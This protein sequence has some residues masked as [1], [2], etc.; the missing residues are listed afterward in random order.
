MVTIR[1][2][3]PLDAP[4]LDTMVRELAACEDSL[5]HVAVDAAAWA[6]ILARPDV[7][8]LIAEREGEPVGFV[9][10]V[11]RLHLWSGKDIL[12]LD[13]LYVRP[14]NRDRGVGSRL[15][16]AV[17]RLADGDN[18]VVTWGARLDNRRAHR[19]YERLGAILKTKVVASWDPPVYRR[20]LQE[21]VYV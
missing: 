9:S 1:P 2:A 17:A 6:D 11:R 21:V 12:A 15:M 8:V 20:H 13:D 10:T 5:E 4:S 19:F 7:V 3:T 14:G 16:A 18:L